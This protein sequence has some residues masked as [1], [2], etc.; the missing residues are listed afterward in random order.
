MAKCK[1]CGKPTPGKFCCPDHSDQWYTM[2]FP[3]HTCLYCGAQLTPQGLNHKLYLKT[4]YCGMKHKGGFMQGLWSAKPFKEV[5]E[6]ETTI[7]TVKATYCIVQM[8]EDLV[9]KLFYCYIFNTETGEITKTKTY[10]KRHV[11]I[12]EV[13]DGFKLRGI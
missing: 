6:F 5:G 1:I 8:V 4:L 10:K 9:N 11:C 7:V 3:D 2:N 12:N 13:L